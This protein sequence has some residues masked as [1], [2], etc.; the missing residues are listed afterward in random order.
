MALGIHLVDLR[1]Y[2][3]ARRDHCSPSRP[4]SASSS[5]LRS[6]DVPLSTSLSALL[7]AGLA[8]HYKHSNKD[9]TLVAMEKDARAKRAGRW[10]DT[11][12][13]P[14]WEWR[15]RKKERTSK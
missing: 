14:P 15:R 13:V 7:T 6:A 10:A 5:G 1:W 8:W 3:H 12:P 9:K 4:L 11:S 2:W